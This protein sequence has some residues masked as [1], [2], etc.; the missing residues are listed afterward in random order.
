MLELTSEWKNASQ[1]LRIEITKALFTE[2]AQK[3]Q[4]ICIKSAF[5]IENCIQI[6]S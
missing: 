2:A 4:E 3:M 5:K 6:G 1:N